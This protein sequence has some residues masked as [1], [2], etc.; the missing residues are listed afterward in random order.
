MHFTSDDASLNESPSI[1]QII[2]SENKQLKEK[3]KHM[4]DLVSKNKNLMQIKAEYIECVNE[5]KQIIERL[6]YK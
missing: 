1:L 4:R 2:M 6:E 3:V 5:C